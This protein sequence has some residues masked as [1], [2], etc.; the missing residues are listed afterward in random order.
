MKMLK[1]ENL[2][3]H[4]KAWAAFILYER[5]YVAYYQGT[6]G[7]LVNSIAVYTVN[8]GFFYLN[9]H[10]VFP[11]AVAGQRVNYA[12]LILM[13]LV[14]IIIYIFFKLFFIFIFK[15][16]GLPTTPHYT[17]FTM[18]FYSIVTRALNLL[19][20]STG[21]WFALSTYYNRKK[22]IQLEEVRL[23]DE[24]QTQTLEKTLLAT[25]NAYLKS[26]INPHFLLNTLNFLYNSVLKYSE[27]V[28]DSFMTLSEIMR[29]ALT[30]ADADG[31]VWL[32]EELDNISNFIKLNQARFNQR[33]RLDFEIEGDSE[34]LRVPPLI[35]MTLVENVFKYGDLLNADHPAKINAYIDGNNLTFITQNLRRKNVLERSHGIGLQNIKSRLSAFEYSLTVDEDE[36][37]YRS[38]LKIQL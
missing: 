31:K 13:I 25:E 17:S 22:I 10:V 1:F 28:A 14:E 38:T 3:L 18:F 15:W 4:I 33:L 37:L 19:A 26:Q 6:P 12:K 8:I 29:Y 20:L 35:L 36:L 32:E 24:V 21:Y 34:G 23:R 27:Q 30:N 5:L 11:S 7:S 9:A 2:Q 16:L